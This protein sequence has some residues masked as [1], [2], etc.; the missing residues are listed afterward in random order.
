[1][2]VKTLIY[3]FTKRFV[4]TLIIVEDINYDKSD[5]CKCAS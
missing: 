2:S 3:M 5:V 4:D 1:M